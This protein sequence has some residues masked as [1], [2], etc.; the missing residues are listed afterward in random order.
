MSGSHPSQD[1]D[2]DKGDF[3]R[4]PSVSISDLLTTGLNLRP[5]DSNQIYEHDF[6]AP[7]Q[8]TDSLQ[9]TT[10]NSRTGKAFMGRT[11]GNTSRFTNQTDRLAK[12]IERHTHNKHDWER[13]VETMKANRRVDDKI[14]TKFQHDPS[15]TR[16]SRNCS[17]VEL[18]LL[19]RSHDFKYD[20]YGSKEAD[21]IGLPHLCGNSKRPRDAADFV[22]RKNAFYQNCHNAEVKYNPTSKRSS[23]IFSTVPTKAEL[24]HTFQLT[25]IIGG[26]NTKIK[27]KAL[28]GSLDSHTQLD[29]GGFAYSSK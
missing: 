16:F 4:R 23:T 25:P 21:T 5:N 24:R 28:F 1:K 27:R 7:L 6:N 11:M 3:S 2:F 13:V 19:E 10:F 17:P 29:N 22:A 14:L 9:M 15:R 8:P 20:Q 12:A 26:E 18:S